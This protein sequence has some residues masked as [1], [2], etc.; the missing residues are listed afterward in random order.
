MNINKALDKTYADKSFKEL[1]DVPVE[2]IKGLSADDAA[3][4]K[5]AFNIKTIGDLANCKYFLWA[6]A[7]QQLATVE[8]Q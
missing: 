5:K 7:I 2:G 6:Q 8:D 1:L 4:L 3:A